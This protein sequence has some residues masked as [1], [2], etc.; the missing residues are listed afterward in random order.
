MGHCLDN[1]TITAIE[2]AGDK[3][4]MRFVIEGGEPITAK[5][6]GDCCSISWIEHVELPAGGFPAKIGR[7]HV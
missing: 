7:A 4:A 6:D 1:Q 2:L 3:K 5:A